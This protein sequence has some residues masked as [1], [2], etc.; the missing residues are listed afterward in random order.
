MYLK[1]ILWICK[2][3]I[4]IIKSRNF[5]RKTQSIIGDIN[6]PL[7]ITEKVNL[8]IFD[9]GDLQA[10]TKK[11]KKYVINSHMLVSHIQQRISILLSLFHFFTHTIFFP[12][13]LFLD[14]A[15]CGIL[16]PQHRPPAVDLQR[17]PFFLFV[18]TS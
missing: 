18:G 7:S 9:I 16:V 12:F 8:K 13:F 14:H 6:I 17:S 11:K 2:A 10:A 3:N 15:A 5:K 4:N 1:H